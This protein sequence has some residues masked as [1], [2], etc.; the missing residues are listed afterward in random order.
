[1][2]TTA[3]AMIATNNKQFV[4][5]LAFQQ[6]TAGAYC[7]VHHKL[8]AHYRGI[9]HDI[10][11]LFTADGADLP[12]LITAK[13]IGHMNLPT[14][15]DIARFNQMYNSG[16]LILRWLTYNPETY[17][18]LNKLA[19]I[20]NRAA[21]ENTNILRIR[22]NVNGLHFK[23]DFEAHNFD[24]I[25]MEPFPD[26]PM[27]PL[28]GMQNNQAPN[29]PVTLNAL[30]RNI[31]AISPATRGQ[32]QQTPPLGGNQTQ[33]TGSIVNPAALPL[34]ARQCLEKGDKHDAYLTKQEC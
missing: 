17:S 25:P 14:D 5:E 6:H 18:R 21:T 26:T 3:T 15:A 7:S 8:N 10:D 19:Y 20:V 4:I 13:V 30:E 22:I 23:N 1:M 24:K 33:Q 28:R 31:A 34:D 9:I 16:A 29:T 2:M 27:T 32:E 12:A 11:D